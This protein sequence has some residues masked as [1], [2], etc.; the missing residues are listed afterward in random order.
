MR[1]FEISGLLLIPQGGEES[2]AK[3]WA[4]YSLESFVESSYQFI[5][6]RRQFA[7]C[8]SLLR[9]GS[10][11]K[12]SEKSFHSLQSLSC[13]CSRAKEAFAEERVVVSLRDGKGALERVTRDYSS[14]VLLRGHVC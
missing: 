3:G 10:F 6:I 8:N 11:I 7:R 14:N 12:K 2:Y 9:I 1:C 4:G 5:Q 13:L